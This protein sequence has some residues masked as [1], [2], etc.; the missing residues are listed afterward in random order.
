MGREVK[1]VHEIKPKIREIREIN[2]NDVVEEHERNLGEIPLNSDSDA[3]FTGESLSIGGGVEQE[4][5][6]IPS[7]NNAVRKHEEQGT[8]FYESVRAQ[9]RGDERRAYKPNEEIASAGLSRA[10][11]SSSSEVGSSLLPE[12]QIAQETERKLRGD[13]DNSYSSGV[14]GGERKERRRYPWEV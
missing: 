9:Q 4:V 5:R 12:E 14:Q 10:R 7:A 3:G 2:R 1:R 8:Q 13:G 6:D 11:I